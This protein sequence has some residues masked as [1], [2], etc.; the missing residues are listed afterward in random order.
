M[1]K[2]LDHVKVPEQHALYKYGCKECK[3]MGST[4]VHLR[5]C[6]ECG[7][8][9]CCDSSDNKHA[10]KH[11]GTTKHPIITSIEPGEHWSYCY[12]D[13]EMMVIPNKAHNQ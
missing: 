10:R 3:E 4:W 5:Q 9:G 11:Y 12:A 7:H 2:H 13:D 8:V 1:C 6:R